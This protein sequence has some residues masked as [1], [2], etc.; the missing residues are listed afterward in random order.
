MSNNKKLSSFINFIK[1]ASKFAEDAH[2]GQ[3]RK[4]G[5]D[6]FVHPQ[7]VAKIVHKVKKSKKI[8]DLVAAAYIHDTVEDNK[9]ITFDIIKDEFGELVMNLVKELTSD[10]EKIK[11]IGKEEY[12]IDKMIQMSN[13]S[14]VIKLADRL[15]N[16]KD[17]IDL[18]KD[19]KY[20]EW[21]KKYYKQTVNIINE[22]EWYRKLSK[23]QI[24]LIEEIKKELEK[25]EKIIN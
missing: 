20:K 14:L 22:L 25:L 17:I 16:I 10:K 23:T 4:A 1:K 24:L 11:L 8:A 6:Y 3:K 5:E 13:W 18:S 9:D 2:K 19:E 12:L 21:T 7:S 15:H